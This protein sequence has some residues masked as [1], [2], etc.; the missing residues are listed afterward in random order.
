M[1]GILRRIPAAMFKSQDT[2]WE[3]CLTLTTASDSS[4]SGLQIARASDSKPAFPRE[5][6]WNNLRISSSGGMI[7]PLVGE[8][9]F[10]GVGCKGA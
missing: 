9:S 5:H 4:L 8:F 6:S 1:I 2:E 10:R 3:I 7:R